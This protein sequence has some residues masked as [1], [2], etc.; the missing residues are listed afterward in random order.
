MCPHVGDLFDVL[1]LGD[2]DPPELRVVLGQ[3]GQ[4]KI[5]AFETQ[6]V[7]CVWEEYIAEKLTCMLLSV[8][9]M[10]AMAVAERSFATSRGVIPSVTNS[11]L[12]AT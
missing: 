4:H 11:S 10:G 1:R 9:M 7:L 6:R 2:P 8:C 12:V 5:G 3:L